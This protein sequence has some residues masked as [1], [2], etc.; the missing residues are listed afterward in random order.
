[1]FSLLPDSLLYLHQQ[2]EAISTAHAVNPNMHFEVFLH[3]V[4]GDFMSEETKAERQQDIQHYVSSELNDGS[5]E[6]LVSYYLTSIYV[7]INCTS[8][9]FL[10]DCYVPLLVLVVL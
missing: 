8:H 1:M 10:V 5:D 4:D 6:I 9:L 2:V 7:S 3:K